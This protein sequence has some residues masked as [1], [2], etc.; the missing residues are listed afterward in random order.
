MIEPAGSRKV[1]GKSLIAVSTA[2]MA[3]VVAMLCRG[4][5]MEAITAFLMT[6]AALEIMLHRALAQFDAPLGKRGRNAVPRPATAA[7]D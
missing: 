2:G 4:S 1:V 6:I 3:I 5:W 7:T